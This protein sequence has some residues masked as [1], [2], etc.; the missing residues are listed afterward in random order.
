MYVLKEKVFMYVQGIRREKR[1]AWTRACTRYLLWSVS[2]CNSEGQQIVIQM[3]CGVL[4]VPV[5]VKLMKSQ[6]K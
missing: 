4:T 1:E 3:G 5:V 2:G 6:Q